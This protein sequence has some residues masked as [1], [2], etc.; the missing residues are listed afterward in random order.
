MHWSHYIRTASYIQL[1]EALATHELGHLAHPL[2]EADALQVVPLEEALRH[3]VS[4][5]L[6]DLEVLALLEEVRDNL[7]RQRVAGLALLLL[8]Q[9]R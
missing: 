5:S 7:H 4:Y 8:V 6:L 1:L 2:Q 9:Q 3:R